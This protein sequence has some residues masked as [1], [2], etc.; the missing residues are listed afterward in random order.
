MAI[1]KFDGL[2]IGKGNIL[3]NGS[4][5]R[6]L[7]SSAPMAV[8]SAALSYSA[9][10]MVEYSGSYYRSISN[11]NLGNTPS[12]VSSYWELYSQDVKDGDI[13]FI[14]AGVFSDI[15]IRTNTRW[16]SILNL[17]LSG[18]LNDNT[19]GQVLIEVPISVARGGVVDYS[20][21][22]GVNERRGTIRYQSNG[23]IVNISDHGIID[24][25]AG[26]VGVTWDAQLDVGLTKIQI[27]GDTDSQGTPASV[28]Y[29]LRGWAQ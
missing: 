18:S 11:G 21:Q 3:S 16:L 9:D 29:T 20:V 25:G 13:A 4:S 26:D 6:Q 12:S 5:A 7:T 19:T 23:S 27:I 24:V 2:L 14:V 10:A 22:R 15:M 17:P 28:K 1:Q 8:Y